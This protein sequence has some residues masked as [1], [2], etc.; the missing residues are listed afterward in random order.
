LYI[1]YNE[2]TEL[3]DIGFLEHLTILDFEANNVKDLD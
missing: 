3:F 2:I 1:G